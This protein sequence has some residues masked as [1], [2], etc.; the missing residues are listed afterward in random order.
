MNVVG[1]AFYRSRRADAA[2]NLAVMHLD[3]NRIAAIAARR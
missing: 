2:A 1:E 3:K